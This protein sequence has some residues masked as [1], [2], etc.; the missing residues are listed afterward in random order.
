ME[1]GGGGL[2]VSAR[3][4]AWMRILHCR[5][6]DALGNGRLETRRDR[7]AEEEAI[8]SKKSLGTNRASGCMTALL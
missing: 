7:V 5:Q 8:E 6:V 3:C 2:G 1:E 4:R